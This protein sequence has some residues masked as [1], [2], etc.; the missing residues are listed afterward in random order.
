MM[1]LHRSI[2][3][4]DGGASQ[5]GCE[6]ITRSASD[7]KGT[8]SSAGMRQCL[9]ITYG[10]RV[11]ARIFSLLLRT[12]FV[13]VLIVTRMRMVLRTGEKVRSL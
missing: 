13:C 5:S 6:R 2:T 8:E 3:R 12:V 10:A 1:T 7:Y 11:C 9:S 4:C